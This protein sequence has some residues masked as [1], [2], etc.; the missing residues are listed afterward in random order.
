MKFIYVTCNVSML[1]A[2]TEII[3]EIKIQNYQVVERVTAKSSKGTPRLDNAVW[4]GYNS[5]IFIQEKDYDKVI[6]LINKVKTMN[7]SAF[8]HSELISLS[9]WD[10]SNIEEQVANC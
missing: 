2:V 6:K 7:D 10:L 3:D 8:N 4:P 5:S 9:T 1:E